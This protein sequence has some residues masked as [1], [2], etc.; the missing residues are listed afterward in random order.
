MLSMAQLRRRPAEI[1]TS[2]KQPRTALPWPYHGI[3]FSRRPAETQ[4]AEAA[5]VEKVRV[6]DPLLAPVMLIGVVAPKLSVGT[7]TAPE[8]LEVTDAASATLPMKPPLGVRVMVEVFPVVAPGVTVAEGPL[9]AKEAG[10]AV[11]MT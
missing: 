6:A 10:I 3:V 1:P 4:L 8:G 2:S 11:T 5:V 9:R 7:S